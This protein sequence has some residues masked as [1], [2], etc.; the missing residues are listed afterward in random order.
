MDLDPNMERSML[1][2]R[3]IENGMSCYRKLYEQKKK[4]TSVQ[5][6]VDKYFCRKQHIHFSLISQHFPLINVFSL[7]HFHYSLYFC[8]CT[9]LKL[10]LKPEIKSSDECC[11]IW[12]NLQ[13]FQLVLTYAYAVSRSTLHSFHELKE[14][15]YRFT[16][17]YLYVQYTYIGKTI[18]TYNKEIQQKRT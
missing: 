7:L 10:I 8:L 6:T 9:Q 5:T 15:I 16:C 1:V 18:E 3:T 13:F 4:A 11:K 17:I 12:M 2:R 14:Y